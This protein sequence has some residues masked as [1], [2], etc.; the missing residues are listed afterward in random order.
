MRE[1]SWRVCMCV[2]AL[3]LRLPP[4]HQVHG[5]HAQGSGNNSPSLPSARNILTLTSPAPKVIRAISCRRNVV[6]ELGMCY[7]TNRPRYHQITISQ[8]V[9][10]GWISECNHN[11]DKSMSHRK[12]VLKNCQ[13]WR[14]RCVREKNALIEPHSGFQAERSALEVAGCRSGAQR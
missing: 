14:E 6:T 8:G 9:P 2:R 7:T 12:V 1:G 5:V 3:L 4:Q 13:W 10:S 11:N